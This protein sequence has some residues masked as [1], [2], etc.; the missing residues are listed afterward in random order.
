MILV[1][2]FLASAFTGW[3][4]FLVGMPLPWILGAMS[5]SA[6][7]TNFTRK[8]INARSVRRLGQLTLGA[9]TGSLLTPEILLELVNLFPAMLLTALAGIAVGVVLSLP[10]AKIAGVDRTTALLSSLPAGMAEMGSL[11]QDIGARADVVTLVH[12]LRVVM[13]VFAAALIVGGNNAQV[14]INASPGATYTALTL[15]LT[16]GGLLALLAMRCGL[17][18]PWLISPILLAAL[19]VSFGFPLQI[20]PKPLVILAQIAI[21][22][23]LGTRLD[24]KSLISLPRAASGAILCGLLLISTM[25]FIVARLLQY[26]LGVDYPTL[27]LSVAPGGLGE[28]IASAKALGT[29]SSMVAAFQFVRSFITNLVAPKVI[30]RYSKIL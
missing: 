3:L 16:G 23:A 14:V 1:A 6:I 27:V 13:V 28:M 18:N 17:I 19:F 21:G 11:A 15:C 10:L 30:I 25:F 2:C 26:W 24:R 20:V 29:A 5:G 22:F 7:C 9:A 4:F 12:T 8:K